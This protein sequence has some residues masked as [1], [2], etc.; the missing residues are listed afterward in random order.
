MYTKSLTYPM[1]YEMLGSHMFSLISLIKW[2][3][4]YNVKEVETGP[5]PEWTLVNL[6]TEKIILCLG[7]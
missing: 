5:I 4:S 6:V 3:L 2:S 1:L 7:I